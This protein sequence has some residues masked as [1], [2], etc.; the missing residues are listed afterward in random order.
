VDWLRDKWRL[1][2]AVELLFAVALGGWALLRAYSPDLTTS[3]GES[4]WRV[5]YLNSI[6]RSDYFPPNDAWLSGY[7]ISY[8]YFGYVMIAM[9]TRLS[10]FRRT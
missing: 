10:D 7:G 5:M 8:Y 9:L 6:G 4:S 2:L 3:G 1:A